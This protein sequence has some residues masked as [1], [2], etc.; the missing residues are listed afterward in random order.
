MPSR[1]FPRLA[2]VGAGPVGLTLALLAARRLPR[3]DITVFDPTTIGPGPV[4]MRFD[5]PGGAGRVYGEAVGIEHVVVNGVRCVE[6]GRLLEARPG[7]LLRSG[8]DTTTVTVAGAAAA[9]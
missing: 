8:R 6:H 7:T 4:A 3:A 1:P 5:L 2:I 9:G